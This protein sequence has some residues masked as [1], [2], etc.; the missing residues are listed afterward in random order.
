MVLHFAVCSELV[1]FAVRFALKD[2]I[3]VFYIH[4]YISIF[5]SLVKIQQYIIMTR[6]AARWYECTFVSINYGNKQLQQ[7]RRDESLLT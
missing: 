4:D 5:L 7:C 6:F 1:L 3:G 2:F